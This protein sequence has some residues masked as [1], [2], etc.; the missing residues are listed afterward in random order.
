MDKPKGKTD[1]LSQSGSLSD[2]YAYMYYWSHKSWYSYSCTLIIEADK[3]FLNWKNIPKN[4]CLFS[5]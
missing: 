4:K 2:E 5:F 3:R 1:W